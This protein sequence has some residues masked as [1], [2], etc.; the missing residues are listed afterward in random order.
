[1]PRF[2]PQAFIITFTAI[3]KEQYKYAP[4]YT[5]Y[6]KPFPVTFDFCE[7]KLLNHAE[8]ESIEISNFYMIGD[9]P[10]S[11][12]EGANRKAQANFEKT[13]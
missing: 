2:G 4:S 10:S 11:D 13:G 9:N 12:I 3:F 6:G 5:T 8:A 7:R 1:M